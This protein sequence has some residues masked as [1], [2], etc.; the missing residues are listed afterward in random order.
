MS[1]DE[2]DL[3]RVVIEQ[4]DLLMLLWRLEDL[5]IKKEEVE[6]ELKVVTMAI[7]AQVE[8]TALFTDPN[9]RPVQATVTRPSPRVD[10]DIEKIRVMRPELFERITKTVLDG[11]ALKKAFKAGWVDT[12]VAEAAMWTRDISPS[13]KLTFLDVDHPEDEEHDDDQP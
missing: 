2:S 9:G 11:P 5:K 12:E 3:S 6:A 13:V 1:E 8:K 10:V 7:E 4:G